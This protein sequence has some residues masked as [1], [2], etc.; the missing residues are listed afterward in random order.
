MLESAML[1]NTGKCCHVVNA[2]WI[3]LLD[4]VIEKFSGLASCTTRVS[5]Q[6]DQ[7]KN[8]G[9]GP[10]K[11]LLM[12][13]LQSYEQTDNAESLPNCPEQLVDNETRCEDEKVYFI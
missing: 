1:S 6:V 7:V 8:S 13:S 10:E 4:S 3:V 11:M 2:E 5:K 9:P 12:R